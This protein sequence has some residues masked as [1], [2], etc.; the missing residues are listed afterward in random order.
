[1][2]AKELERIKAAKRGNGG[3]GGGGGVVTLRPKINP[4]ERIL[5]FG[6]AG[7][8]KST[9]VLEIARLCPTDTFYVADSEI[10]N[11][12][13]L[14]STAF[15]DLNNVEVTPC[16][17][18]QEWVDFVAK[19]NSVMG[20]DDWLVIDMMTPLWD[21]VQGWF[22]EKVHGSDIEEFFI[23]KRITQ[24]KI[25]DSAKKGQ[26]VPRG[27]GAINGE[28]G[29]WQVINKQIFKLYNDMMKCPGHWYWCA[30]QDKIGKDDDKEVKAAYGAYG[31]K[32]KGQKK[33]PHVPMTSIWLTKSRVGNWAMTTIKDRG[34][35]EV[36]DEPVENFAV[37]YLMNI[38]GWEKVT[39]NG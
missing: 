10:S 29:D 30:E 4:R 33:L 6:T 5:T 36:E 7:T 32:P 35:P 34:R 14:L 1:M 18:W 25:K 23:E 8:G 31:I 38:A 11:Y 3:D 12:D 13:R 39:V 26:E 15:T 19:T 21:A 17:E 28:D 37:D 24:Q 27:F 16:T 22:I 20:R 9:A 2:D